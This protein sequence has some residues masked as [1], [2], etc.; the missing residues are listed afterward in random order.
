VPCTSPITLGPLALGAHTFEVRARDNVG[1]VDP[2]PAARGVILAD[3][4]PAAFTNYRLSPTVFRA[5]ARGPS[6]AARRPIGTRVSYVL[7]ERA[8]VT[9]RVERAAKGRRVRG[10]CRR[11]TPRNRGHRPC[12][13]Y[14]LLAGSFRDAGEPGANR[15]RFRGRLR[16]RKLPRGSYRLRARPVDVAGNPSPVARRA[17]RIVRR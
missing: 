3:A 15:F 10:R 16:G 7:S 17:F 1:N 6:T 11:P 4:T 5:A 9:F 12:R 2:T 8:T 14:V 13:R